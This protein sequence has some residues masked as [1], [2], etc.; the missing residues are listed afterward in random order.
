MQNGAISDRMKI[1]TFEYSNQKYIH[2]DMKTNFSF[3][4]LKNIRIIVVCIF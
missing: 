4:I 1:N 2:I 3:A